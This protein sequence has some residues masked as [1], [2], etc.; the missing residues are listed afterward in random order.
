[1]LR[2]LLKYEIKATSRYFLP[3]Y[4]VLTVFAIIN[5]L[6]TFNSDTLSV[7]QG[8]TFTLYIIILVGMF[9]VSF[10]VM[11]QRFYKNLLSEEGYLMFTLPVD[12]W[13]H[14]LSKAIVSLMW[15]VLSSIVAIISI[16]IIAL[17][18]ITLFQL[19]S[20]FGQLWQE[21]YRYLGANTYYLIIQLI[22]AYIISIVTGNM[23]IYVS[24]ALGHLSNNHKILASI[25]SFLGIYTIGSFISCAVMT[26]AVP[27][28]FMNGTP[29]Q[30]P[31]EFI[32]LSIGLSAIFTV[33]YFIVTNLVLTKRL[34]LE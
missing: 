7:S 19:F 21:I 17:Q 10:V 20:E 31:F 25:G 16:I 9:V 2:K 24:I 1:M 4:L 18:E 23:L 6:F 12:S 32:W 5:S 11:I 29:M 14:I 28:Y 33:V 30:Y 27:N 22:V 8:I 15:T 26:N 34:N 3:I 13:R